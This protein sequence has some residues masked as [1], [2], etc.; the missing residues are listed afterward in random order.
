MRQTNCVCQQLHVNRFSIYA[1]KPQYLKELDDLI[2]PT[3][4]G[5]GNADVAVLL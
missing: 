5:T 1:L 3:K 2:R 4:L